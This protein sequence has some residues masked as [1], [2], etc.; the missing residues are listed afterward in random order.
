MAQPCSNLATK[1]E[2]DEL[3]K[4]L[5]QKLDKK[6]ENSI[7]Q[8]AAKVA[9][10]AVLGIVTPEIAKAVTTAGQAA[11]TASAAQAGVG[12]VTSIL[13]KVSQDVNQ[14]N[15]NALLA[16]KQAA[17]SFDKATKVASQLGKAFG[18]ISNIFSI[19]G[20][21]ATLAFV[22]SLTAQVAKINAQVK[23]NNKIATDNQKELALVKEDII[24]VQQEIKANEASIAKNNAVIKDN[25]AAI[26]ENEAF[27]AKAE[28][29]I[30]ANNAKIQAAEFNLSKQI[31][32]AEAQLDAEIKQAEA[33][34]NAQI[35]EVEK[36][37]TIAN[38]SIKKVEFKNLQ[39][40]TQ[41]TSLNTVIGGLNANI[42]AV[43][44]SIPKIQSEV[45]K[46]E[47]KLIVKKVIEKTVTNATSITGLN[48]EVI[49]LGAKT[50]QNTNAINKITKFA[51]E[52]KIKTIETKIAQIEST[53]NTKNVEKIVE[54]KVQVNNKQ[55][56]QVNQKQF[57]QLD[58]KIAGVAGVTAAAVL[59]GL[60][61][62]LK[63]LKNNTNPKVVDINTK[64]TLC[65][66]SSPGGCLHKNMFSPLNNL[67]NSIKNNLNSLLGTGNAVANATIISKLDGLKPIVQNTNTVV[68]NVFDGIQTAKGFVQK[69]WKSLGGDKILNAVNTAMVFHN[70]LML[71]N[72]IAQSVGDTVSLALNAIGVQ[73]ENNNPIDVN[74]IVGNQ[75]NS[76]ITSIIG[77]A[78]YE[79]LK[80]GLQKASR[81]HQAAVGTLSAVQGTKNA[82]LEAD[83][84]TGGNIA[85]IGNALQ[86][87]GVVEEDSYQWMDDN[88]D[89]K[90]PFSGL[91]GKIDNIENFV[92]RANTIVAS[93]VE[94]QENINQSITASQE[95]QESLDTFNTEKTE[96]ETTAKAESES[97]DID[98]FDLLETEVTDEQ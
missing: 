48:G 60:A 46:K 3:K 79:T 91:L 62:D 29:K 49:G 75:V 94:L 52:P 7:I 22:A 21:L 17:K 9:E 15:F 97:P 51:S 83:E 72:N 30:A 92:D 73:D 24:K 16:G 56:E 68:N 69:A 12:K 88:P 35:V 96:A 58:A 31:Q 32:Q 33:E 20:T 23:A 84:V 38:Q 36:D 10:L 64:K 67:G 27:I 74:Q 14:A 26:L 40:Q 45:A 37:V 93:G 42:A 11:S 1:A 98:R 8:S 86:E 71:S 78:N 43:K 65:D 66:S 4:L 57:E 61:S 2:L 85:K 34:L 77:A 47:D 28:Q 59:A 54:E 19:I 55:I 81:I 41:V 90:T 25:K 82:L 70:A 89:Y 87:Q 95:L 39:L 53:T 13:G 63:L 80:T 5:D 50:G 76:I 6:Q 18:L 44:S